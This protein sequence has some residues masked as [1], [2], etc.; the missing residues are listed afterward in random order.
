MK[1]TKNIL[2]EFD[3]KFGANI[4][5]RRRKMPILM[6]IFEHFSDEIYGG[7]NVYKKAIYEKEELRKRMKLN[8]KQNKLFEQYDE[9]ENLILDDIVE[10]AFIYGFGV[11]EELKNE[12]RN[13][14]QNHEN[15][16]GEKES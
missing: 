11:S 5:K 6:G 3:K 12:V 7:S 10:T 8:F 14:A 16:A 15:D 2:E 1:K 9:L 13:I 4:G